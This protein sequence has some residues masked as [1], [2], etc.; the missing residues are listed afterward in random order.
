MPTTKDCIGLVSLARLS[1]GDEASAYVLRARVKRSAMVIGSCLAER[2]GIPSPVLPSDLADLH[3]RDPLAESVLNSCNEML[4]RTRSL[5][6]PSESLDD[7][8]R[9]G[10]S[11]MVRHLHELETKLRAMD[12]SAAS[13]R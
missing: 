9:L 12:G 2:F 6:Q 13:M 8:W 5:C 1:A 11:E 10:W 7:R 4:V 3:V